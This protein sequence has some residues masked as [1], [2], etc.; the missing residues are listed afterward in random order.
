MAFQ[1]SGLMAEWFKKTYHGLAGYTELLTTVGLTRIQVLNNNPERSSIVFVNPSADF[2]TL[3]PTTRIA[4]GSGIRLAPN[5]GFI[6]VSIPDD[7]PLPAMSWY[8]VG[9]AA[10]LTLY[11]LETIRVTILK[12]EE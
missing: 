9:D 7:A 8:A 3:T 5:G 12:D 1:A 4:S 2:I 10:G 11:T 6:S